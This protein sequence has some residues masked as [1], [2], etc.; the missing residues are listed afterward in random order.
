MSTIEIQN[1]I[2]GVW[3]GK[4]A[5]VRRNPADLDEIVTRTAAAT[6]DEVR[7]AAA[8]AAK[9]AQEWARTPAPARGRIL[10]RAGDLI[11]Q[12]ADEIGDDIT[13]EEG[14]T[15]A[16]ARG[17]ALRAAQ[18]LR[19]Y[20]NE[21]WR[22]GGETYPS[23][24]GTDLIYS[25]RE[26]LGV[27]SVITPWNFPIAIPTWKTA[28][29]LIAGNAVL[30]KPAQVAPVG[31]WHLARALHDAGLPAGVLSLLNG[32]GSAVGNTLIDADEVAAVTFTGSN[33]VGDG[34]YRRAAPR[35]IRVQL[36]MGGKNAV[37]VLDDADPQTAAEVVA[38]GAFGLTGQACT[39]TSR[40]IVTPG[41]RDRFVEALAA[42]AERYRPGNGLGDGVLMG[43]VVS[44]DQLSSNLDHLQAAVQ[45][46]AR[47]VTDGRR[48][49]G[50]MMAPSIL[51]GVGPADIIAREEVFGPVVAVLDAGGL[52]AA[53]DLVNDSRFGLSAGIV[54]NDLAAVHRFADRVHA[55]VV[56][57]NRPTSGVELNTPF[58]GVGDSGT[59]T[60]REQ[61]QGAL[62]FF[63]WTKSVYSATPAWAAR[64]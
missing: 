61:G 7:A 15:R 50:L 16:E 64:P 18:L 6:A 38:A 56:K 28:P 10:E 57:V 63:T 40:V 48:V 41:I 44:H 42:Q 60:Y 30:L 3:T 29:A 1:L 12:R 33:S 59:N 23:A 5:T 43:P 25:R 11:E 26:P 8:S 35:R 22:L 9:A 58:G 13:R 45:A 4:P 62:D 54:T 20:G 49:D 14:K 53:I 27:V 36:E 39:A 2:D 51:T 21:G 47:P 55:G 46:G 24:A 37:I 19:F 34:I 52:D 31:A 17:E 32:S